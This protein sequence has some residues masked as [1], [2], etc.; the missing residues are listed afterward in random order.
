MYVCMCMCVCE[1]TSVRVYVCVCVIVVLVGLLTTE[2]MCEIFCQIDWRS[3]KYVACPSD[4][5][6]KLFTVVI[7]SVA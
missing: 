4:P 2:T 7:M 3:N 5:A 6:I 1:C